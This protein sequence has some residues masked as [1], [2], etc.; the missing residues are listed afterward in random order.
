MRGQ[1]QYV[2]LALTSAGCSLLVGEGFASDPAQP[3]FDASPPSDDASSTTDAPASTDGAP[4]SKYAAAVLADKPIGY[5]RCGDTT[6]TTLADSS[7]TDH[8]ATIVAPLAATLGRPG[9]LAGDPDGAIELD[10]TTSLSLGDL[11]DFPG[12]APYS[13]E[14]W[15]KPSSNAFVNLFDK[16]EREQGTGI[17]VKGSVFYY[18]PDEGGT[19]RLALERWN[20]AS[21]VS[22]FFQDGAGALFA[23]DRFT[24]V[25]IAYDGTAPRL[26]RD[27]VL[28]Q[29]GNGNA[30]IPDNSV[31]FRWAEGLKGTVDELA[32]YDF[33]LSPTRIE[34]HYSAS[35]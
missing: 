5:W 4:A 32:I 31:P 19:P 12:K 13:F 15:V 33:A 23:A 35:K 6:G 9:A 18:R 8:P 25:V 2:L 7:G 11:F 14:L 16:M 26:F 20:G 17:P 29:N 28:A 24:H 3:P 27:G 10:G 1:V 21:A 22:F 34:A 30:D